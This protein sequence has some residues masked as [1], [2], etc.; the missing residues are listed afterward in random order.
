MTV[1]RQQPRTV[2]VR[3]QQVGC[4]ST[5]HIG[6]GRPCD[7]PPVKAVAAVHRSGAR[8]QWRWLPLT[9]VAAAGIGGSTYKAMAS[10]NH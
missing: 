3:K 5:P 1:R 6:G 7:H 9:Q 8:S 10:H 2:A 4:G